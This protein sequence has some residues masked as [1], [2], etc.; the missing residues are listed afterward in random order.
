MVSGIIYFLVPKRAKWVVLLLASY[1]F[2]GCARP[3][4]FAF[5]AVHYAEY[6]LGRPMAF[7]LEQTAGPRAEERRAAAHC[8]GKSKH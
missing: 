4:F 3:P 2:Y 5:S 7:T 8:R 1:F 6:L